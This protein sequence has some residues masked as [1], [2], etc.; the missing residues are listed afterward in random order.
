MANSFHASII[1]TA[2]ELQRAYLFKLDIFGSGNSSNMFGLLVSSTKTP[3]MNIEERKIPIKSSYLKV[4]NMVNFETWSAT[5]MDKEDSHI[6]KYFYNWNKEIYDIKGKYVGLPKDYK[7]FGIVTLKNHDGSDGTIFTLKG[8]WPT[9]VAGA[10]L[11]YS[12]S[13][14]LKYTITFAMDEFELE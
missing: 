14:L 4:T 13:D 9:N 7:R 8:I 2:G 12:S 6:Y 5:F 1:D 3:S 10:E 11:S